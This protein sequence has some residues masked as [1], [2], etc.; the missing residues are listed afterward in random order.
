MNI[1]FRGFGP[2]LFPCCA[3]F[4][5]TLNSSFLSLE[6][7]GNDDDDD[8]VNLNHFLPFEVVLQQGE[9]IFLAPMQ[10]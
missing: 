5:L 9:Q 2:L 8:D 4:R 3:H 10:G 6:E 1:G 7:E